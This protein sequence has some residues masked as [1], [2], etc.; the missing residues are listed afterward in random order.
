MTTPPVTSVTDELIAELESAAN[1]ATPGP[2][3]WD[4]PV[5]NYDPEEEAPWLVQEGDG[6]TVITGELMCSEENAEF[7]ALANP[8]T[9]LA[10]LTERAELKR[11]AERLNK[12]DQVG[13]AYGFED[14]HEGNRWMIDGPYRDIRAAIDAMQEAKPCP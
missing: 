7:V 5:W 9:I 3:G 11:D 4:G 6:L 13:Y 2:W 8:A 12:L 10:L 1:A 14:M